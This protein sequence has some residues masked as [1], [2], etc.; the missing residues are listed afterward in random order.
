MTD[1]E[2][3]EFVKILKAFKKKASKSKKISRQFLIDVGIIT[4]NGKLS[5]NYKH[6]RF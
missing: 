4:L 6:I 2:Y 5:K 1:K 3:K